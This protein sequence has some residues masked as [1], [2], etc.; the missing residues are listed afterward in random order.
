M[1]NIRLLM[2]IDDSLSMKCHT[3]AK[4]PVMEWA[5]ILGKKFLEEAE[6]NRRVE[7][8]IQAESQFIE[9]D[10]VKKLVFCREWS[11]HNEGMDFFFVYIKFFKFSL[12]LLVML[13]LKILK[14]TGRDNIPE[15]A[16]F[17]SLYSG[18]EI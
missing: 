2:L 16:V 6:L 4:V 11:K 14:S 18:S 1:S 9:L 10:D 3:S 12:E 7:M 8:L 13:E 17:S 5:S 15:Q